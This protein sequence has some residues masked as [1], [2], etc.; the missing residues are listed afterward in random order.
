MRTHQ[1][2]SASA[3]P[4]RPTTHRKTPQPHWL[5]DP[6]GRQRTLAETARLLLCVLLSALGFYGIAY[7]CHGLYHPDLTALLEESKTLLPDH[8]LPDVK[9][10]PLENL[11]YTIGLLYFPISILGLYAVFSC[12]KASRWLSRPPVATTCIYIVTAG[13]L[14]LGVCTLN[15]PNPFLGAKFSASDFQPTNFKVF[16][17]PLL[18]ARRPML[19]LI[20]TPVI[21]GL[22]FLL[23][24][25]KPKAYR[26]SDLVL[27]LS[28]GL[29]ALW[30]LT[31]VFRMHRYSFP[32]TWQ[33]QYDFN[34]VYYSMTQTLAGSPVLIDGVSNTYGGYP[35]FLAP[36]FRLFGLDIPHFTT[37]MS[38]L[39]VGAVFCW[40]IFLCRFS[41]SRL[42]AALGTVAL[43]FFGYLS[44][45]LHDSLAANRHTFDSYFANAPIRWVSPAITLLCVALYAGRNARLRRV[46]Y[47]AAAVLLPLGI[48]WCPDFGLISCLAWLLFLLYQDF[49][50]KPE[51]EDTT[52]ATDMPD[53]ACPR[54][55]WRTELHHLA[56][57]TAGLVVSFGLFA[58]IMRGA[59]G[60]WP[61]YRLLFRTAAVFGKLGFFTLPM[62]ALH[63]W[64]LVVLMFCL[65]LA[66]SLAAFY[67]RRTTPRAA[68]IFLLSILGCGLFAY[69]KSRSYHNNLFQPALY[70]MMA[71]VLFTDLL[72]RQVCENGLRRLWFPCALGLLLYGSAVPECLAAAKPLHD[73]TRPYHG[74]PPP[75]DKTRILENKAFI[76]QSPRKT[77]KVWVLTS[78]KF[79]SFYFDNPPLQSAFNPG[80]LDLNMLAD[81]ERAKQ[82]LRD[83]NFT[84]FLDGGSFYYS[85]WQDFRSLLAARYVVDTQRRQSEKLF[86]STLNPRP[87]AIPATPVLTRPDERP[88]LHR[89]YTDTPAGYDLRVQD[90]TGTP[91]RL[92]GQTFSVEVLFLTTPQHYSRSAVFSQYT[93]STGFGLFHINENG[94][95]NLF[96]FACGTT[97]R[98][99]RLPMPAWCYLVFNFHP[100]YV[101]LFVNTQFYGRIP[102]NEPFHP[103][104]DRFSIGAHNGHSHYFGAINE[105]AVYDRTKTPAEIAETF[106]Q[107]RQS[108]K[109]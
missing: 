55:A 23:S 15:Q 63:P 68:A 75:A 52:A 27:G 71:G 100:G 65:G 46:V 31:V 74:A 83:S 102:L 58:L 66:Y 21:L 90:A 24:R 97:Q 25:L 95:Y 96:G 72:W 101:D 82:T 104:T 26:C 39:I 14:C 73:L 76:R 98:I 64:M 94:E 107:F 44:P 18:V 6:A 20:C 108:F 81:E 35:L 9:P 11:L 50:T 89:K 59:Y 49:W 22:F 91:L 84:V 28:A 57:W 40:S 42:L 33:G 62:Q 13:L 1:P 43:L 48:I 93:D 88:L 77:E 30:L 51:S 85:Q 8:L 79:Q 2:K 106:E 45:Y 67:R 78:N 47:Y 70:A 99:F 54:I 80:F 105:I 29:I 3:A 38:L 16:F 56:V 103:G 87:A 37:V 5:P 17:A 19:Y 34:A 10:E 61:D 69:F 32:E 7:L 60:S 86:F 36:L 4:A 92:E 12:G 41:R 109:K 53:E